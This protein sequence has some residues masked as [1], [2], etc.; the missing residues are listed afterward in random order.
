M[1]RSVFAG[2]L[3]AILM[4]LLSG[5]PSGPQYTGKIDLAK[6]LSIS[7][8][9]QKWEVEL[10]DQ[11]YGYRIWAKSSGIYLLGSNDTPDDDGQLSRM[12]ICLDPN[13]GS[14]RWERKI[15]FPGGFVFDDVYF[16]PKHIIYEN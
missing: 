13:T 15:S 9:G 14:K 1:N 11:Y 5:C 6:R 7:P 3:A 2:V 10:P 8:I 16:T 12:F 4:F